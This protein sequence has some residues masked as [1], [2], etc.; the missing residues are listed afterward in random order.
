MI[1]L[2][3]ESNK[4]S[5]SHNNIKKIKWLGRYTLTNLRKRD[6]PICIKKDAISY[7]MPDRDLYVLMLHSIVV[8]DK[9]TC[10]G[11]L[12]NGDTIY[13][14]TSFSSVEYYHLELDEHSAIISNGLPSETF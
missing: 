2:T 3:F 6:Y 11:N 1:Y 12:L 9:M 7:N 13:E 5:Q 14:D 8:N 10:A 4:F